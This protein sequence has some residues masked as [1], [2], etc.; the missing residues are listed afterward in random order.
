MYRS[1]LHT[2]DATASPPPLTSHPF[3]PPSPT[4]ALALTRPPL[5]RHPPYA[6]PA[7]SDFVYHVAEL[8]SLAL[9]ASCVALMSTTLKSTYQKD[10]DSF[11]A[12]HVP[13][14]LGTIYIFVPCLVLALVRLTPVQRI[15][16]GDAEEG[17][18]EEGGMDDEESQG[19]W[20]DF[21]AYLSLRCHC[22]C[23]PYCLRASLA[24]SPSPFLGSAHPPR[25]SFVRSPP[26]EGSA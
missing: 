20:V 25:N 7:A 9:A 3:L 24:Q 15:F 11:G 17:A 14:E 2:L 18:R 4:G 16:F 23:C 10:V 6:A 12:L 8:A 5:A 13:T 26:G 1:R 21:L 19:S 22:L